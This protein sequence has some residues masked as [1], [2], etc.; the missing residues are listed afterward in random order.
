MKI[1]SYGLLL[2]SVCLVIDAVHDEVTGEAVAS[3]PGRG[4]AIHRIDRGADPE[5]FRNLMNYQWVRAS[6]PALAGLFF[7]KMIRR[8]EQLDPLSPDFQGQ[9]SLDELSDYLD[10]QR[11]GK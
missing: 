5:Q 4:G 7:L 3:S 2:L 10:S 1:F 11:K 6:L 8:G 9:D